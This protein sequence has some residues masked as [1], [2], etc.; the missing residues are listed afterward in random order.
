MTEWEY[1]TKDVHLDSV[2]SVLNV[3]GEDGWE[4]ASMAPVGHQRFLLVLKRPK[5]TFRV[6][7]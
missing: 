7:T 3:L 2:R 6:R 1:N 4:L 5:Q